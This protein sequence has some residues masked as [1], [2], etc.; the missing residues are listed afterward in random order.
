MCQRLWEP[1]LHPSTI[2]SR[3]RP[4]QISQQKPLIYKIPHPMPWKTTNHT[5]AVRRYPPRSTSFKRRCLSTRVESALTKRPSRRPSGTL[6]RLVV[7]KGKPVTT[8]QR[9]LVRR[10]LLTRVLK[11]K[12]Q[13]LRKSQESMTP[14]SSITSSSKRRRSRSGR[15]CIARCSTF[16]HHIVARRRRW[17][18]SAAATRFWST[19]RAASR[20]FGSSTLAKAVSPL[21]SRVSKMSSSNP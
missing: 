11:P 12:K 19:I 18:I 21:R 17:K 2:R 13:T 14:F 3:D 4:I 1:H 9:L 5:T 15:R 20:R 7:A 10:L 6:S 8:R 16:S